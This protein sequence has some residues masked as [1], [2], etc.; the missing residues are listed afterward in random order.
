MIRLLILA[1]AVLLAAG[2]DRPPVQTGMVPRTLVQTV[3]EDARCRAIGETARVDA[4]RAP[5][6]IAPLDLGFPIRVTCEKQGYFPTSAV[7]RPLPRHSL[8]QWLADGGG[9]S[10][11]TDLTPA[12]RAAP[13]APP[14]LDTR[15]PAGV[16]IALHP[17]FFE[18]P[19]D[20]ATYYDRLKRELSGRWADLESRLD[21]ECAT[22]DPGTLRP[23]ETVAEICRKARQRFDQLRSAELRVIEIDRRRAG[24]R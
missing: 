24:F 7:L 16:T 4:R 5:L 12:V 2:C 17:M 22:L 11:M 19:E 10:A 1:A 18:T 15:V 23:K 8:P 14:T 21:A 9:V 20:R 13:D 6:S 3:P